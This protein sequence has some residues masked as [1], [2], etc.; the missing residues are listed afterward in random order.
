M[1]LSVID[2]DIELI[3]AIQALIHIKRAE[4]MVFA[5][6]LNWRL[7]F[8]DWGTASGTS[9]DHV[10][11]RW[12]PLSIRGPRN[13]IMT[14]DNRGYLV[15]PDQNRVIFLSRRSLADNWVLAGEATTLT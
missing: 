7:T 12:A 5:V 11:T 8:A 6:A 13:W 14:S 1:S 10:F 2:N 15:N 9:T 3:N 4:A